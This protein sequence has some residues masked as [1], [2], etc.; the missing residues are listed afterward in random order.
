MKNTFRLGDCIT[1]VDEFIVNTY[2]PNGIVIGIACD[3]EDYRA[4]AKR[5]GYGDD[6]DRL[7]RDH[8]LAHTLCAQFLGLPA[9]PV[10]VRL[11]DNVDVATEMTGAMED[12]ILAFQ[13]VS[14]ILGLDVQ[15]IAKLHAH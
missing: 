7:N 1:V 8:E 10:F 11:A 4:T 14:L 2:L 15:E 3:T 5:L 9:C 6:I 12:F 13:R